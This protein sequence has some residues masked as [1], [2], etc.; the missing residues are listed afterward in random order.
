M[1]VGFDISYMA[2]T[3]MFAFLK[4]WKDDEG[5]NYMTGLAKKIELT[6]FISFYDFTWPPFVTK[7]SFWDPRLRYCSLV[8]V[9]L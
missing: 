3:N 1:T 5:V 4:F 9:Q 2:F 8:K 6:T 7:P